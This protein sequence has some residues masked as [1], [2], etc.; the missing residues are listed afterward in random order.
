MSEPTIDRALRL[1]CL[2]WVGAM[3]G[4]FWAFSVVVMPGLTTIDPL[5][6]MASMQAINDAVQNAAFFVGFFGA[7]VFCVLVVVRA[8]VRRRGLAGWAALA[9][10]V[11]YVGGVFAVTVGFNVPLNEEL[12][13]LDP[14][15]A[16]NA[17]AMAVYLEDWTFWNDVRSV[18]GLV[19]FGLL[20]ASIRPG[21]GR[22]VGHGATA[23]R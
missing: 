14:T 1:L 18:A 12:A 2:L 5:A 17:R 9:G 20:A 6:A 10:G 23:Q 7:P 11:V 8:L 4:F 16:E 3:A 13:A 21:R 15:R 22:E 19:A